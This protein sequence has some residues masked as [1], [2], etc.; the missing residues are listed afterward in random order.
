M[1]RAQSVLTHWHAHRDVLAPLVEAVPEDK[2]NYRP[3]DQA[4]SFSD[5]VWHILSASAMFAA[6]AKEGRVTGRTDKPD[7]G[8]K[9]AILQAISTWTEQTHAN[10]ASMTDEQFERMV[11]TKA[12]FG[13]DLPAKV[14]LGS[15]IDHE[16]HHKGQLFV[17]A[18]MMG[19]E[20]L[21]FF[22]HRG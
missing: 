21:P 1:S 9:Q 18:R 13:A 10:I 14:L 2:L 5:L 22:I 4:M 17:Y 12:I 8:S 20:K 15:M 19:T 16:V 7:L 3:W 6:A 11:E